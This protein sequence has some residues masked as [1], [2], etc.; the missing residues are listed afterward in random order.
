MESG[1]CW[2]PSIGK[3][4]TEEKMNGKGTLDQWIENPNKNCKRAGSLLQFGMFLP[5]N[6]STL[7]ILNGT[8]GLRPAR[9]TSALSVRATATDCVSATGRDGAA[10]S[11]RITRSPAVPPQQRPP[12]SD[13]APATKASLAE[14]M[15]AASGRRW[16]KRAP[17]GLSS[18]RPW[19]SLPGRR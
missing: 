5:L 11:Q 17:R 12:A 19:R 2:Q 3:T 1:Q 16:L 4:S 13:V 9:S 14:G 7:S 8:S 6:G 10:A 18:L 15:M